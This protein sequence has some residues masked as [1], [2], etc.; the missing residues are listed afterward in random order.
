MNHK[1][2]IKI[3]PLFIIAFLF[4]IPLFSQTDAH[5]WTNQYGA[6]GLLLNGAVIASTEDETAIF[7]NPGAMGNGESFGL[8]LSFITPTFSVLK[9]SNFLGDGTNFKDR[10]LGFTSGFAA[11]GFRLFNNDRFRGGA[12]TFTRFNSGLD[13][14]GKSLNLFPDGDGLIFSGNLDFNRKLNERWT[15][16]GLAFE[17][18][19]KF[20]LGFSQFVVIHNESNRVNIGK[21]I[22]KSVNPEKLILSWRTKLKYSFSAAGGMLTKFGL[23]W[24]PKKFMLGLTVTTPIYN[25]IIKN[26]SYEIDDL[27]FF[28]LDSTKVVSSLNSTKLKNYKTPWSFGLG[29]DFAL[30]SRLRISFSTEYFREIKSY[31]ILED[32]KDPYK[33]LV[34]ENITQVISIRTSNKKVWNFALGGQYQTKKNSTL[35][36]GVRTDFNQRNE[37]EGGDE[38]S[39]LATTPDIYYFSLG[40]LLAVNGNQLSLGINYGIGIR[41][42]STQLVDFKN[43]TYDNF[44][45]LN[46]VGDSGSFFQSIILVLTYD[47]IFKGKKNKN[48]G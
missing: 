29:L 39:F 45:S 22:I 37:I 26:A 31:T 10:S 5:Y 19:K 47:F 35:F 43:I 13:F 23:S 34:N 32:S 1:M 2:K 48:E 14:R 38:F 3:V 8:S 28:G 12:T 40:S 9:T 20:S 41:E 4:I 27:K 36:F 42:N 17:I 33:G 21:E 25:H 30:N 18:F 7:Y 6:K 16:F 15:G 44:Y 24:R 46:R 11:V